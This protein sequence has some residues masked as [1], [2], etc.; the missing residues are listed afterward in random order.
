MEAVGVPEPDGQ[1]I[2]E[3]RRCRTCGYTVRAFL[4]YVPDEDELADLR[5]RLDE[6]RLFGVAG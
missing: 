3:Y 5:R 2:F 1:W 4:R 6:C